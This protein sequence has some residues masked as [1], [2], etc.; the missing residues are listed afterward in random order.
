MQV[1]VLPAM[2]NGIHL[3][4]PLRPSYAPEEQGRLIGVHLLC[5]DGTPGH[6][7]MDSRLLAGEPPIPIPL[8]PHGACRPGAWADH[9]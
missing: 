6:H 5:G 7:P 4:A 3:A 9:Q 1:S 2:V 8:G